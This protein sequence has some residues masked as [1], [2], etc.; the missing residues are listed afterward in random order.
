MS[1]NMDTI[2]QGLSSSKAPKRNSSAY[3]LFYSLQK[4]PEQSTRK[5]KSF[6]QLAGAIAQKWNSMDCFDREQFYN[7]S[8]EERQNFR[9]AKQ[10]LQT[11]RNNEKLRELKT[12]KREKTAILEED[13]VEDQRPKVSSSSMDKSKLLD[14]VEAQ[15]FRQFVDVAKQSFEAIKDP[16]LSRHPTESSR[17]AQ[18]FRASTSSSNLM[19]FQQTAPTPKAVPASRP[20]VSTVT[21]SEDSSV[22]DLKPPAQTRP[23]DVDTEMRDNVGSSIFRD[24]LQQGINLLEPMEEVS[25]ESLF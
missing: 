13:D 20:Q 2:R 11:K 8:M 6:L 9:W 3:S 25:M 10:S 15:V 12:L 21:D 17:I 4:K 7:Q 16:R 23:S 14:E 5:E 1:T 19:A 24:A 22:E 18:A